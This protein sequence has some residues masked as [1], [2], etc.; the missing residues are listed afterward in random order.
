GGGADAVAAVD[1]LQ[2]LEPPFAQD[3]FPLPLDPD[4]DADPPVADPSA[5]LVVHARPLARS[6]RLRY[7]HLNITTLFSPRRDVAVP[8]RRA[9][10][11]I[12]V[13]RA[14]QPDASMRQAGKPDLRRGFT[15]IELL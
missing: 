8:R 4:A 13:G 15:L 2:Q 9:L 11:L 1:P 3:R 5:R 14:F 7:N 12:D 6:Q 10:T